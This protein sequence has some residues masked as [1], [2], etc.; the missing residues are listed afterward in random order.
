[1][2]FLVDMSENI[3]HFYGDVFNDL[4]SGNFGKVAGAVVIILATIFIISSGFNPPP[5]RR[6]P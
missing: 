6:E 5:D 2:E 3:V 4:S 1:M